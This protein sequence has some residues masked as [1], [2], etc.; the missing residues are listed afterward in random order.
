VKKLILFIILFVLMSRSIYSQYE[1]LKAGKK[2]IPFSANVYIGHLFFNSTIGI[3][4]HYGYF[5]M[6]SG[7]MLSHMPINKNKIISDCVELTAY[8]CKP[9]KFGSYISLGMISDAYARQD[10]DSLS[11][12][13]IYEITGPMNIVKTGINV[14]IKISKSRIRNQDKYANLKIG[15]GYEWCKYKKFYT[16]ETLLSVNLFS[17]F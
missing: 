1:R 8:S 16:F 15:V 11:G 5:G 12:D 6:S 7:W 3:D 14:P 4:F 2:D 17:K 10:K 9:N 13:I